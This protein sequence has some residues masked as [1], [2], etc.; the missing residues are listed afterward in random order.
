[1]P[2]PAADSWQRFYD[3]PAALMAWLVQEVR[4]VHFP[5]RP[6]RAGANAGTTDSTAPSERAPET[7]H[8][9]SWLRRRASG[10]LTSV[11]RNGRWQTRHGG[12]NWRPPRNADTAAARSTGRPLDGRHEVERD[13]KEDKEH[14][15]PEHD[16]ERNLHD[17]AHDG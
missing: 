7:E 6:T 16:A 15:H 14:E 5:K 13:G 4:T 1:V 10:S 17:E 9:T 8:P 2:A 12:T 3:L 11:S